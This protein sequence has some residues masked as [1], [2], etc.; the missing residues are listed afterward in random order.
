MPREVPDRARRPSERTFPYCLF[1]YLILWTVTQL[2][3]NRRPYWCAA[4]SLALPNAT[5]I[6]VSTEIVSLY[7]TERPIPVLF[8]NKSDWE[9]GIIYEDHSCHVLG[10]RVC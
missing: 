10:D 4:G 1:Q 5:N 8:L 7:G 9:K 6:R 3:I 2:L